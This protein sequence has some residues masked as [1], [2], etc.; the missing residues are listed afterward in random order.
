VEYDLAVEN[1]ESAPST[2]VG[3]KARLYR[4][5]KTL[6]R[7]IPPRLRT[8]LY[9]IAEH[10]VLFRRLRSQVWIITGEER[11]SRLPLSVCIYSITDEYKSYLQDLIFG[12]SFQSTY[13]G[14]AWLWKAFRT[15]PKA[16]SSCSL[17]IAEVHERHVPWMGPNAGIVIP[18]WVLGRASLPRAREVKQR[19]TIK[20]ILRRIRQHNL[21]YD[22]ARDAETFDD[23]YT[24]MYL[25]EVRARYGDS[26]FVLSREKAKAR[27]DTGELIM[28]KKNG[29]RLCGQLISYRDGWDGAASLICIG[30]RD[31]KRELVADGALSAAYEFAF[32]HLEKTG[33]PKVN[34]GESNAFL[35]DGV[36]RFKK[37]Y[38]S[39]IH[40]AS[41]H[42]FL[43]RVISDNPATRAFLQG[44]PFIFQRGSE[45]SAAVFVGPEVPP[46]L[47]TLQEIHKEYSHAGLSEIVAFFFTPEGAPTAS[48]TTL[49]PIPN[50]ATNPSIPLDAQPSYQQL[51]PAEFA[52][53]IGSLG[54]IGIATAVAIRPRKEHQAG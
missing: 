40:A 23:F 24:N 5:G 44:N 41:I 37:K 49:E 52:P 3:P 29:R 6:Y 38:G 22:V 19:G 27:F 30:V 15:L 17:V 39:T 4:L 32:Q 46:T 21:E 2:S 31:G 20:E 33:C 10:I 28:V 47:V 34:F 54:P 7:A 48:S 12:S 50:P 36:L 53:L 43:I 9:P 51:T 25:P 42:K 35:N 1:P 13:V 11:A 45:F 18:A 8:S 16:A 26:A 14:R